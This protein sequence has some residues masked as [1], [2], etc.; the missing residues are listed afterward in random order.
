M[1][2]KEKPRQGPATC[3]EADFKNN[4]DYY[5]CPETAR[6]ALAFIDPSDRDLWVRMAMAV[7]SELGDSGF[8]IW[9]AW[10]MLSESYVSRDALAVWKSSRVDGGVTI[11]T[12][13][14]EAKRNG[15]VNSGNYQAP[16]TEQIAERELKKAKA[17]AK[18]ERVKEETARN[19]QTILDGAITVMSHPY[20]LRKQV[21]PTETLREIDADSVERI[22][23]YRPQCS[24]EPLDGALIVVPVKQGERISTLEL[25]DASGRKT[26]LKGQGTKSGGYWATERLKDSPE[27]ILLAEGVATALSASQAT[28]YP[29]IASLSIGNMKVVALQLREK[30]PTAKIVVLADLKDSKPHAKAIEAAQAIGAFLAA[31]KLEASQGSDFNDMHVSHGLESVK[32]A[33]EAA[34]NGKAEQEGELPPE[35]LRADMPEPEE[36]P[37][38]Q[39]GDVLGYAAIALQQTI[40][41]PLALCCQSVLGAAS[42][43]A[44]AHFNVRLPWG[45]EKPLSLFLLTVAESGER[46]SAVDT[47]TLGPA[48]QQE[49][50]AQSAYRSELEA[51]KITDEAWGESIESAKRHVKATAKGQIAPEVMRSAMAACGDR[52][53]APIAPL[54]F[55]TDPTVEG[56]YKL[57]EAGQPSVAL[58]SD[59]GGLLIG[60]HAL[61][62]DNALKTMARWCKLWDGSPFDRVRS[63]DGSGILY[64]RRMCLHQLAQ[65][66]VMVKLLSDPMANGQGF[67]ARCLTAWPTST[68]GSRQVSGFEWAGDRIEVRRLYAAL[69]GLMEAPPTVSPDNPQELTPNTLTLSEEAQEIAIE[70]ANQFEA[71][72]AAGNDLAELRDRGSKALENACRIAGVFA[73]I[74]GGLA[75]KV[76]TRDQLIRAVILVQ[77]Y[78]AEALRIHSA[79]A[80]PQSITD[81]ESLLR[82]L[83]GRDMRVFRAATVLKF[84]PSQMRNKGRL[85]KAIH[86]AVKTGHLTVLPSGTVVDGV[87]AR[88]SWRVDH[89]V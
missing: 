68:I 58:F 34:L 29:A 78:L 66:E 57:F 45:D 76:I 2:H 20:L 55:V 60:G 28:A 70:S 67:L 3:S 38:G 7:K 39:L 64:G 74:D 84:G 62:S 79:A 51:H 88:K 5:T 35:P 23:G 87:A 37:V 21:E 47:V 89:V 41:A 17:E 6:E 83:K 81:A 14:F 40:R 27:V 30:Y 8:E 12:L 25:I 80:V 52:P 16:S 18:A 22:L 4:A 24:G 36:Y 61:N 56:L 72:M 50:D 43:A 73:V 54:R 59:E 13:F 46:K 26:A 49:R 77:W 63:G 65:P 1:A 48:R 42:L 53:A 32:A 33:I 31:P 44:Q 69:T 19:A 15:W 85:E 11:A 86:E 75:A 71:L 9:D 10:S 82:W